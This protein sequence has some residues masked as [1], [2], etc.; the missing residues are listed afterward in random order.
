MN[1]KK[2]HINILQTVQTAGN[3][4]IFELHWFQ[5]WAACLS[6]SEKLAV[7]WGNCSNALYYQEQFP[8]A[9]SSAIHWYLNIKENFKQSGSGIISLEFS[10][11]FIF[12]IYLTKKNDAINLTVKRAKR[13][14]LSNASSKLYL[15]QFVFTYTLIP[16]TKA[17]FH[18]CIQLWINR[19]VK[20]L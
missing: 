2:K 10:S 13:L 8:L 16:S 18:F 6:Q 9:T 15:G 3:L 5:P 1:F 17:W 7:Q 12:N 4:L 14:E 20:A 19:A 11:I